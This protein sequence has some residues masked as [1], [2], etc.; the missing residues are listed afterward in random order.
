MK[1]II[2]VIVLAAMIAPAYADDRPFPSIG[3][4]L[5]G[6]IEALDEF[7]KLTGGW[8]GT[9]RNY[10]SSSWLG[11]AVRDDYS[12]KRWNGVWPKSGMTIYSEPGGVIKEHVDRWHRRLAP[13]RA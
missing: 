7:D 11:T 4:A 2:A 5:K 12:P 1:K 3:E 6:L 8:T 13:L 10:K 9:L